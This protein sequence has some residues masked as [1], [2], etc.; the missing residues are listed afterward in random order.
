M[1]TVSRV[2]TPTTRSLRL[3][4][5]L[6]GAPPPCPG[7][8][9]PRRTSAGSPPCYGVGSVDRVDDLNRCA[10][11]VVLV[12]AGLVVE[13]DGR[14]VGGTPAAHARARRDLRVDV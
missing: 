8:A 1:A 4:I 5:L 7:A 13:R 10:L 12:L 6:I 14:G 11:A 9:P 2:R 3:W